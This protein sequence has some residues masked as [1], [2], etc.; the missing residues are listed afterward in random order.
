M[1]IFKDQF[2]IIVFLCMNVSACVAV[3]ERVHSALMPAVLYP[4]NVELAKPVQQFYSIRAWLLCF[5]WYQH[6]WAMRTFSVD[7]NIKS[8]RNGSGTKHFVSQVLPCVLVLQPPPQ[9][10]SVTYTISINLKACIWP[11]DMIKWWTYTKS[12]LFPDPCLIYPLPTPLYL[13]SCVE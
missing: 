12:W 13:F 11:H 1:I 6:W 9:L 4:P 8:I 10:S 3:A 5:G 2:R 7:Q